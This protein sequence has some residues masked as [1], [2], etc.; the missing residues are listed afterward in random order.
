[1]DSQQGTQPACEGFCTGVVDGAS[2]RVRVLSWLGVLLPLA[3]FWATCIRF[4]S[5]MPVSDDYDAVLLFLAH[6][7]QLPT[8]GA[9]LAAVL[10]HQHNEYKPIWA[11]AIIALQYKLAGHVN[12][13]ALSLLGDLQ[14]MLLA[15]LLWKTFARATITGMC[16]L[17]LF[18]PV[19]LILFQTNYGETLDWP[20]PGIQN[21]GVVMFAL[22]SLWLL[23]RP[24]PWS[25]AGAC[26]G[27]ALSIAASG[28]G[29]FLFP[30][31]LLLLSQQRHWSRM[32][33]WTLTLLASAVVY[34]THY[35]RSAPANA[36]HPGL[37]P[38]FIL[39]FLGSF[40]GVS[41]PVV[42]Y[43]SV[44]VGMCLLACAV[45]AAMRRYQHRNPA[46]AGFALFLLITALGVS[47]T[48][49][50]AGYA[51]SLSGR[52]KIYSD[53]LLVCVYAFGLEAM[54]HLPVAR[55]RRA[56]RSAVAVAC[57]LFLV[58]SAYGV[59]IMRARYLQLNQGLAL[60]RSS[61]G[62]EGPLPLPQTGSDQDRAVAAG[63]D[64]HFRD[65]LREADE[66][67]V[68]RLP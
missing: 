18:V 26:C 50:G 6:A 44:P 60:Y 2:A 55:R 37:H 29:F 9:R 49:G 68:Y 45:F 21:L 11:N 10:F 63:F 65:A 40:A 59:R 54:A 35:A 53:L 43:A 7:R 30:V 5:P 20:M 14:V 58:G 61:N 66:T 67:H 8:H 57:L 24:G 38:I 1:M 64:A 22:L 12:F 56:F 19:A 4:L 3:V 15:W 17:A 52:Y 31:G 16:R 25:F 33:P 51:Q 47:F 42:R 48:R 13:E 27:L 34:F 39:S 32:V 62:N 46:I 28:N 41:L 36:A 23:C